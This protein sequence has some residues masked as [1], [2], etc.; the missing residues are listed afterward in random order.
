V[1]LTPPLSH[2]PEI[3]RATSDSNAS[4]VGGWV[5]GTTSVEVAP[6]NVEATPVNVEAAPV[7]VEAAPVNVEAAPVNVEAAQSTIVW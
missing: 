1:S 3:T 6:V 7:N 5:S 4:P 2:A